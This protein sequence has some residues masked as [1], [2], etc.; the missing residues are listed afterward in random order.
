MKSLEEQLAHLQGYNAF[1]LPYV[2][3]PY[4]KDC[5][6]KGYLHYRYEK[7]LEQAMSDYAKEVDEENCR[8]MVRRRLLMES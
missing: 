2:P 1:K 3:N 7:G 5:P 6:D 4:N 8:D